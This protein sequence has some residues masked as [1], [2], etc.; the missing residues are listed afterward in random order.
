MTSLRSTDWTGSA[1]RVAA[2]GLGAVVGGPLGGALG[3]WLGDALG[4]SAT[5][6]IKG[7]AE[8]FGE[9]AAEKFAEIG[10]DSLAERLKKPAQLEAVYRE[11]LRR[12]LAEIRSEKP[13]GQFEDWF[14]NWEGCLTSSTPLQLTAIELDSLRPEKLDDLFRQTMERIDTQG[15]AIRRKDLSLTKGFR[16]MSNEFLS[17]LAAR[18][19]ERLQV[20]FAAL[21]VEPQ[22][23]QAWKETEL[24]FKKLSSAALVRIDETTQRIDRKLENIEMLLI[25]GEKEG[26]VTEE[27]L[28]TRNADWEERYREY[29]QH[30][31]TV[32]PF[33]AFVEQGATV[34][35]AAEARVI[36][37]GQKTPKEPQSPPKLDPQFVADALATRRQSGKPS[38]LVLLGEPGDGKT[39]LLH[40]LLLS[41]A[42]AGR[43]PLFV[44]SFEWEKIDT[45]ETWIE[46]GVYLRGRDTP[47]AF[48]PRLL[49][50]VREG[51]APV[52]LD[53]L[54]EVREL[55]KVIAKIQDFAAGAGK[56]AVLLATCR[57]AVY[58]NALSSFEALELYALERREI[59][60]YV[61]VRLNEQAHEFMAN[62]DS[63]AATRALAGNGL[64]LA[65]MTHL[66]A[67]G[68]VQLPTSKDELYDQIVQLFLEDPE[69]Q[70]RPRRHPKVYPLALKQA[71]LEEIA[72]HNYFC[73]R[74]QQE[75]QERSVLATLRR[76]TAVPD[77]RDSRGQEDDLLRDILLNNGLLSQE[78]P[79]D[80]IRFFH[81]TLQEYFAARFAAA[82]WSED[83][84]DWHEW[85]PKRKHWQWGEAE[86]TACPRGCENPLPTFALMTTK[87]EYHEFL[88][89]MLG[90]LDDKAKTN[91][92]LRGLADELPF[93]HGLHEP[94]HATRR[95]K[96]RFRTSMESRRASHSEANKSTDLP[97][98]C[99]PALL[100][101]VECL[102][103]CDRIQT[104][105]Q[106]AVQALSRCQHAFLDLL[107]NVLL[108]LETV[109][110]Q[111]F[112]T[113][114]DTLMVLGQ[115]R[116]EAIRREA[117]RR[118]QEQLEG[119]EA[120]VEARAYAASAL[121]CI[122]DSRAV[123][124]L[125]RALTNPQVEAW[126]HKNAAWALGKL[127][128]DRAI[129]ALARIV[130][131]K[132]K[133][134]WFSAVWAMEKIGSKRAIGALG[135]ILKDP[136]ANDELRSNAADALASVGNAHAADAL[137]HVMNDPSADKIG[138]RFSAQALAKIGDN[139]A[140]EA[141][142]Q[143]VK[144]Q[145]DEGDRRY[146]IELALT[147]GEL[148][149]DRAIDVLCQVARDPQIDER[150]R[151]DVVSRL[152][153]LPDQ[154]VIDALCQ[155]VSDSHVA[156]SVRIHAGWALNGALT[157][158]DG[159]G[160]RDTL[161]QV[162]E[163][164][165][166]EAWVRNNVA[167]VLGQF[168]G[169][170]A[171]EPLYRVM[172]D[173]RVEEHIR[174]LA[175]R[176][177]G[178][179]GDPRA[180]SLLFLEMK[181]LQ[182]EPQLR[183][184]AAAELGNIND[185]RATGMLLQALTDSQIKALLP[186]W[187]PYYALRSLCRIGGDHAAEALSQVMTSSHVEGGVRASAASALGT[188]R[189]VQ[190]VEALVQVLTDSQIDAQVRINA[191][192]ALAETGGERAVA[193]LTQ[194]LTDPD[195]DYDVRRCSAE[196]LGKIG[197][198]HAIQALNVFAEDERVTELER[199]DVVRTLLEQC[200]PQWTA[201]ADA[202]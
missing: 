144:N 151:G 120:P 74:R 59:E 139:R 3:G 159:P 27:Q 108:G 7:Y 135:S 103:L 107:H 78:G 15:A 178:R 44:R 189:T 85:L 190:A 192:Q 24:I 35:I 39:T 183:Y 163:D 158:P 67:R 145:E 114:D 82:R 75:M 173:T 179:I 38:H 45:L 193:A 132:E 162:L 86:N 161:I 111:H 106:F 194:A 49:Q 164:P 174:R 130:Y 136:Q 197:D 141:L 65:M 60:Q 77:W 125:I 90:M 81:P 118:Y 156:V 92:F 51:K 69:V 105:L 79:G 137:F 41:D 87:A 50:H 20:H 116:T 160:A 182:T 17:E 88:L 12:S 9:K 11:A 177:L 31:F 140:G 66:Y 52:L 29:L 83:D 21:I 32:F 34:D 55:G 165:Q 150:L 16:N 53:G 95:Y 172:T 184:L 170:R 62:L 181:D 37:K 148:S 199:K 54:D 131:T 57:T 127:G 8:K 134:A 56:N 70:E 26:R 171:I 101:N 167:S 18:L 68:R 5:E 84:P 198:N 201:T 124:S 94:G 72:F 195:T 157:R 155:I 168:G 202:G 117:V 64:M 40:K 121:G 96:V 36:P 200:E 196:A 14:A 22:Y 46:S 115:A 176:A 33:S 30:T 188:I 10:A 109:S 93:L 119:R 129:E 133:D 42:R 104:H 89:L 169:D 80:P 153:Y 4:S 13:W 142:I 187:F 25:Q 147:L 63:D 110:W 58:R 113:N 152:Q 166:T 43:F 48:G 100:G 47:E 138:H 185:T 23:E 128:D 76:L 191:G 154:R 99:D 175:A 97:F 1:I 122:G 123:E 126:I 28:Q 71:V 6:I 2:V 186:M 143:A 180:A 73:R 146:T 19:P 98:D 61:N 91:V 102:V 112:K 149:N